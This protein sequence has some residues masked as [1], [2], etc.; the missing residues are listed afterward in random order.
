MYHDVLPRLY[1]RP[2]W[3]IIDRGLFSRVINFLVHIFLELPILSMQVVAVNLSVS[4]IFLIN[5]PVILF[6]VLNICIY[7]LYN[8][9][10]EMY[11]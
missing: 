11:M 6:T 4:V 7:Q 9:L 1:C 10:K 8:L 2:L 5:S 3:G